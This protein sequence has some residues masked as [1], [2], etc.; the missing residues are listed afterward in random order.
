MK[1][2]KPITVKEIGGA[3]TGLWPKYMTDDVVG[4]L[5]FLDASNRGQVPEV[6]VDLI[7]VIRHNHF[8]LSV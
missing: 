2:G 8:H 7:R 1:S 5:I 4:V 3:V 6:L